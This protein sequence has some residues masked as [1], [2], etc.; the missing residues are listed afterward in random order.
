MKKFI[1]MAAAAILSLSLL[2]SCDIAHLEVDCPYHNQASPYLQYKDHD[3]NSANADAA[4][5]NDGSK[6]SNDPQDTS[7]AGEETPAAPAV[8]KSVPVTIWL[9]GTDQTVTSITVGGLTANYDGLAVSAQ[10]TLVATFSAPSAGNRAIEVS[11]VTPEGFRRTAEAVYQETG[12]KVLFDLYT[13][14]VTVE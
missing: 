5:E 14:E 3:G 7:A 2:D 8:S 13:G 9:R 6:V 11:Y 12:S 1:L 10:E 4:A